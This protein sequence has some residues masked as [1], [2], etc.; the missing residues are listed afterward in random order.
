MGQ[1]IT[2]KP[3]YNTK[4]FKEV[5]DNPDSFSEEYQN[6]GIETTIATTSVAT[7]YYLLYA[8]HGND[9]IANL[10]INQWKYRVWSVIYQYGPTWE[11]RLELQKKIR[12]LTLDDLKKGSKAVYNKAYNPSGEP[13]TAALE[14][15]DFISEQNTTN[16][17]RADVE[18]YG[19]Q[20]DALRTDVT[21]VFLRQFDKLFK[22]FV[23]HEHPTLYFSEEDEEDE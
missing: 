13:G 18:A 17:K 19:I 14:E 8:R 16:Y 20:W 2:K 22:K 10:D 3:N 12:S 6:N 23:S 21:E 7:L 9:P 5:W 4:L 11:K 15:I 1:I